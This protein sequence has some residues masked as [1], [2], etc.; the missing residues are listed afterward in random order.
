MAFGMY[1]LAI[2]FYLFVRLVF[3]HSSSSGMLHILDYFVS[4]FVLFVALVSSIGRMNREF[5][6]HLLLGTFLMLLIGVSSVFRMVPLPGGMTLT[7]V[8]PL[9]TG[10]VL[11]M[12]CGFWV[13]S[14]CIVVGS[15]FVGGVGPWMIYQSLFMGLIGAG[16]GMFEL[17][18]RGS[19][20]LLLVYATLGSF[21]F[22]FLMN[23][24]F[25][26]G[27]QPLQSGF[28]MENIQRYVQF[29]LAS[30]L[31]WDGLRALGNVVFLFFFLPIA[32]L[33]ASYKGML[34]TSTVME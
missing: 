12:S 27:L 10:Y 21:C 2:V 14:I 24:W 20:Y 22:G 23:F 9:M 15:F 16:A 7:F 34:K 6:N 29:Y 8:I 4:S 18:R 28:P 30:S 5:S 1:F 13:G 3:F 31:L 17:E 26:F 32:E 25:Y 33:L 11:G 19:F